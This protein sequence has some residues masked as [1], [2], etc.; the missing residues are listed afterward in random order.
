MQAS[1]VLYFTVVISVLPVNVYIWAPFEF[2]LVHFEWCVCVC[3]GGGWYNLSSVSLTQRKLKPG[4]QEK[5]KRKRHNARMRIWSAFPRWRTNFWYFSPSSPS[6]TSTTTTTKANTETKEMPK[7]GEG[8]R[9]F[10]TKTSS[11]RFSQHTVF[12]S[13][14]FR[15][16][17]PR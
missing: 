8:K 10:S 5:S 15:Y 6:W 7:K 11:G 1:S 17:I 9:Y 4:S 13:Y 12:E 14:G 16:V 3:G 2:Y